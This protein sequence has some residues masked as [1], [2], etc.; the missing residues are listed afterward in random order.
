MADQ[1]P[2]ITYK[3]QS[4][5]L[6]GSEADDAI[7]NLLKAKLDLNKMKLYIFMKVYISYRS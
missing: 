6:L 3:H 7:I 5:I 1:E 4:L 2:K